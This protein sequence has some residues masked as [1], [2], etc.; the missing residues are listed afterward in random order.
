MRYLH[1]FA[2]VK[3][4]LIYRPY[5]TVPEEI[6]RDFYDPL[7]QDVIV[8]IIKLYPNGSMS[9]FLAKAVVGDTVRLTGPHK[10]DSFNVPNTP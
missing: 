8:F 3:K 6:A 2:V 1:L 4:S 10:L 5:T 7:G 9:K